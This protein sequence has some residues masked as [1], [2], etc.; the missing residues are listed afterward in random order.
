MLACRSAKWRYAECRMLDV[1]LLKGVMLSVV[2]LS[3]LAYIGGDPKI[4]LQPD[5]PTKI[6]L[7]TD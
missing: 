3:V 4:G 1:V 7:G 2:I 6:L 5:F